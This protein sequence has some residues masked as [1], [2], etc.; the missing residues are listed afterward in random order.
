MTNQP[1]SRIRSVAVFCGSRFGASP[2]YRQAAEQLGSGL[3]QPGA[4]WSMAAA[5]SG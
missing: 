2:A 1:T 5:G 3:A 4:A